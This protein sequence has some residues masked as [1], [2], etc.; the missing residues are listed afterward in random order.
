VSLLRRAF[1][2]YLVT[3]LAAGAGI[4][5]VAGH[6]AGGRAVVT[7]PLAARQALRMLAMNVEGV[8]QLGLGIYDPG[9]FSLSGAERILLES[10]GLE[11]RDEVSAESLVQALE[12]VIRE[13]YATGRLAMV[14]QYPLSA[15]EKTFLVYAL[16]QQ[17]LQDK[18][19]RAP[20]P[21]IHDGIIAEK[22][23]FG[24]TF[25][26]AG[27]VFNEQSDGHG[28][29][30]V[31]ADNTPAGTVITINNRP[32]KTRW[33]ANS[34]TGAVYDQELEQMIARPATHQVALLVPETGLR[35]V[36]GNLVVRPRPK[37][38]ALEGGGAS[39]VFCEIEKWNVVKFKGREI[40][41][42]NTYCGPRSSTIFVGDLALATRVF[43]DRIEATLD[44]SI[45]PP[46]KHPVRMVDIRSGEAVSLGVFESE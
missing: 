20:Q 35:Q 18:P 29:I 42:V 8:H 31:L 40:V 13:D 22:V 12:R 26:V 27:Q 38:A 4:G 10:L 37:A 9:E 2:R 28:G 25:T 41:R 44:R 19:Y 1:N 23:K 7:Q 6:Y 16:V 45:V 15:T 21:E 30:W 32:V 5:F 36:L 14:A 3:G 34:L 43:P 39:T 11:Q 46:G 24:P 33:K 17:G